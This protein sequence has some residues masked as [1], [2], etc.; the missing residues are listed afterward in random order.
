MCFYYKYITM[1]KEKRLNLIMFLAKSSGETLVEHTNNLLDQFDCLRSTYPSI[2]ND[3]QWQ[4]LQYA[5]AYHDLGKINDLFQKK[6]RH[7][8]ATIDGEIPHGLLSIT[9]I[10]FN[11]LSDKF[12]QDELKV[13]AYAVANHHNRDFS[14]IEKGNYKDQITKLAVNEAKLDI[15]NLKIDLPIRTPKFVSSNYY[16][17][18]HIWTVKDIWDNVWLDENGIKQQLKV[19]EL[20]IKI[21]GLLN[22]LDYAASGHYSI[23]SSPRINE[24]VNVLNYLGKNARYNDLQNWTYNH[25]NQSIVVIAQTG[26]GKTESALRWFDTNKAFFVLP[27]KTAINA[28][29]DRLIQEIFQGDLD[30]ANDNMAL[31]HSDMLSILV[32]NKKLSNEQLFNQEINED[33]EWS[34]QL[35]ITTLDQVFPFVYHYKGYEPKIATLAY[36]KVVIDEIQMY[37]PDLLAYIICGL[38]EIQKYGGKFDVMTATLAPAV[39]DLFKENGIKFIMPSHAF[40]DS[41]V[42]HRHNVKTLHRELTAEDVLKLDQGQ[43]TLV[44]VNTVK[45]AMEMYNELKENGKDIHL[46][47]SRFTREDR[48]RKEQEIID[49]AHSNSTGIWIGTQVVEA[50]LDIDFDVLITELSELNGL[51]Q[52]M[53]RCYRKRNYEGKTPNV[54]VFDGGDKNPSGINQSDQSVVDYQMYQLSKDAIKDI[55]GYLS[56]EDKLQLINDNYTSEKFS[57]KT[58]TGFVNKVKNDLKS[59]TS[60]QDTQADKAQVKK[61][62]RKLQTIDVIPEAVYLANK[63]MVNINA[64][65]LV[66]KEYNKFE[67]A[68]ARKEIN[69]LLVNV[70]SYIATNKNLIA[71]NDLNALGYKILSKD[72][73]YSSETG[74]NLKNGSSIKSVAE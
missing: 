46:I 24:S 71:N 40:L 32:N 5:C 27:L 63:D 53:G 21:K 33:R 18:C 54:Y 25:R 48:R 61:I 19:Y 50:S 31:L 37:S 29:Y 38:K 13:L 69:D 12:S 49:F 20:F 45:K 7:N 42:D 23:E 66:N 10:D 43:K 62:F 59:L 67:Y 26:L 57:N 73:K 68:K 35:S 14:K 52:R 4:L 15:S 36:S 56:E 30:K 70:Y 9:M 47:H 65:K 28:I 3:H 58:N 16:K 74:L 6:I 64:E 60:I 39:L 17:F 11:A 34:K 22:R 44:I 8:Q 55:D 1:E 2:L 72:F 51:F 41:N